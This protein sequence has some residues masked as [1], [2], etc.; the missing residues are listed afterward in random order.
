MRSPPSASLAD[1][2]RL[3]LPAILADPTLSRGTYRTDWRCNG[4]I[5]APQHWYFE[6]V[7]GGTAPKS[8]WLRCEYRPRP[9]PG[10]PWCGCGG[11]AC[12][13]ARGVVR[14]ADGDH[15]RESGAGGRG[16]RKEIRL[17]TIRSGDQAVLVFAADLAA[18]RV[19]SIRGDLC[20]ASRRSGT[21]TAS[22]EL[23]R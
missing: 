19:P 12:G 13:R 6:S 4:Q 2:R 18:Q 9:G 16:P 17:W 23:P 15:P 22:A 8:L 7:R 1:T 20:S 21:G 10:R 11:V 5:E 14:A 3:D